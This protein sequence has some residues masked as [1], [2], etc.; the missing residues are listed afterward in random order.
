MT[1]KLTIFFPETIK[2]TKLYFWRNFRCMRSM[3]AILTHPLSLCMDWSDFTTYVVPL[4]S[5]LRVVPRSQLLHGCLLWTV[6]LLRTKLL[7]KL[8][9]AGKCF[10]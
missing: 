4:V 6:T 3:G 1:V 2:L 5:M 8:L 10:T 9:G 7:K